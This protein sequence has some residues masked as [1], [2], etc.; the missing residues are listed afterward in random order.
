M[1]LPAEELIS[2]ADRLLA[3]QRLA[4]LAVVV[5]VAREVLPAVV[6]AVRSELAK[7]NERKP[8]KREARPNSRAS[9]CAASGSDR[10]GTRQPRLRH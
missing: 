5:A 4:V 10:A 2:A 8:N 7:A 6:T 1:P 3:R 9:H